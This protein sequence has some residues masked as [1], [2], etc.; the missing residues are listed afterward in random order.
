MTQEPDTADLSAS[1]EWSTPKKLFEALQ[2][3]YGP[4]DVDICS[5]PQNAL[6]P[7]RLEDAL[8]QRCWD[9]LFARMGLGVVRGFLNPPYSRGMLLRFMSLVRRLVMMGHLRQVTCIVPTYS[10]TTWWHETVK[11][12]AGALHAVTSGVTALGPATQWRYEEMIIEVIEPRGRVRFIEAS[13][14]TGPARFPNA[15][16]TFA[17]TDSLPLLEVGGRKRGPKPVVTLALEFAVEDLIRKNL[18]ISEACKRAG[19]ARKTWY[20]HLERKGRAA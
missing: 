17:M 2:A 20:R 6:L 10:D 3:R 15:Y 11:A 4:F 18:S 19:I 14:A 1:N 8:D 13:G 12:P 9:R 16:V 5:S 7:K